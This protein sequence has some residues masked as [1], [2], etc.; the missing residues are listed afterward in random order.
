[1]RFS[2]ALSSLRHSRLLPM[3]SGTVKWFNESKG[4][5]A[6]QSLVREEAM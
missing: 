5:C 3:Q 4:Y 2:C 1:L 6:R